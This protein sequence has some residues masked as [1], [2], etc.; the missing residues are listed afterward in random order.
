MMTMS[1]QPPASCRWNGARSEY[2]HSGSLCG[3]ELMGLPAQQ[4]SLPSHVPR[5]QHVA[6]SLHGETHILQ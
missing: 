4:D 3:S 2:L 1:R 5:S 6:A